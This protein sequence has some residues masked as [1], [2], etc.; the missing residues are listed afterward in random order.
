[1]TPQDNP[2]GQIDYQQTT[3]IRVPR[4]NTRYGIQE[5]DWLYLKDLLA[6]CGTNISWMEIVASAGF[7]GG[8]SFII[9][10]FTTTDISHWFLSIGCCLAVIGLFALI[11]AIISRKK[12]K[13]NIE[14]VKKF[15]Q[16][17]ESQFT[18]IP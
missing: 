18:N 3:S 11:V 16:H 12:E 8:I 15:I 4:E 1:M 9:A 17:I 10:Y 7:S 13:A 2:H 5:T 14:D 6:R